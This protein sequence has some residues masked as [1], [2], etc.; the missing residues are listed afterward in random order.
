[1][2]TRPRRRRRLALGSVVAVAGAA[3]A[4]AVVHRPAEPPPTIESPGKPD[5]VETP[6]A[7]AERLMGA[8][9]LDG[10]EAVLKTAREGGDSA[11]LQE[12]L[13][14]CAERRGNRLGALAHLE[15]AARLAP[16]DA[17]PRGRLAAL[18]YRLGHSSEACKTARMALQLDPQGPRAG[19]A[20]AV[21]SQ[22]RCKEASP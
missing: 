3:V 10:A 20:R 15:R 13:A 1:M 5:V 16:K 8:G 18:L 17:E 6:V 19:A 4:L 11:E 7:R 21:I 14:T 22:A 9:D 12:A 2:F